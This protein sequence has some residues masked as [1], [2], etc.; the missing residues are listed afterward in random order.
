M[1]MYACAHISVY[2]YIILKYV[3]LKLFPVNTTL[4]IQ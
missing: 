3:L 1:W 4:Q 2:K